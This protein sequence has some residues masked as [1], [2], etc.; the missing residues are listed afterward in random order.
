MNDNE[1]IAWQVVDAFGEVEYTCLKQ[2]TAEYL[3]DWCI[4]DKI[5]RFMDTAKTIPHLEPQMMK[6]IN[7]VKFNLVECEVIV[8]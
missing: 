2:S 7:Y 1:L 3:R 4:A 6:A 5:N 8:G